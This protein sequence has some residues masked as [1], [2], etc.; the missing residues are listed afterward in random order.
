LNFKLELSLQSLSGYDLSGTYNGHLELS[1]LGTINTEAYNANMGTGEFSSDTK[2]L[3]TNGI[4]VSEPTSSNYVNDK[5]LQ[6][7]CIADSNTNLIFQQ[8]VEVILSS[9][10]LYTYGTPKN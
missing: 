2:I 10:D 4:S 1:Q 6:G 7:V 3:V 9:N 5:I 8:T